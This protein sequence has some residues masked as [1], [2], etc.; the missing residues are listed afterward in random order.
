MTV[1]EHET[2][3]VSDSP[4]DEADPKNNAVDPMNPSHWINSKKAALHFRKVALCFVSL[5]LDFE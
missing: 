4:Q 5:G 2:I 3:A 1:V